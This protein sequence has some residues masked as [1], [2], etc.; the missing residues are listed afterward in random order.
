MVLLNLCLHA[1]QLRGF[2]AGSWVRTASFTASVATGTERREQPSAHTSQTGLGY[3]HRSVVSDSLPPDPIDCSP[4][5]S[6]A[7]GISQARILEWFA[8]SFSMGS[9]LSRNR[10]R[11]YLHCRQI[12]HHLSYQRSPKELNQ[13]ELVFSFYY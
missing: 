4:P 3:V 1:A 2:W 13:S 7:H 6:S 11:F 12:L 8:I 10:A 9:S 5:G